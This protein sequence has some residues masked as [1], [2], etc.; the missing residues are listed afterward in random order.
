MTKSNGGHHDND[1]LGEWKSNKT[2][3]T[4]STIVTPKILQS[5]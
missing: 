2:F 3:S 5:N 1:N 4:Y